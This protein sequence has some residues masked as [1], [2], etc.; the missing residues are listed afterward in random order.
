MGEWYTK[1]WFINRVDTINWP[2]YRDWKADVSSVSPSS[3]M[4]AFQSLYGGQSTL[5]TLL[6]NQIFVGSSQLWTQFKQ[7][8]IEAWKSQDFNGVWTSYCCLTSRFHVDSKIQIIEQLGLV[9]ITKCDSCK[10]KCMCI[11]LV[12]SQI[13]KKIK[14]KV[15]IFNTYI[16]NPI[17]E[18]WV[19]VVTEKR[20]S[21]HIP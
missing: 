14:P 2:P 17:W 15:K 19:A 7:L 11:I 20:I 21:P 6:I 10:E 3:K 16:S 12:F 18:D 13:R 1:I 4:S 9:W 8:R 5:S